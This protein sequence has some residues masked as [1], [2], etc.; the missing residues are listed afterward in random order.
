M[1]K[2]FG[3]DIKAP[4]FE[5]ADRGKYLVACGGV[6]LFE[7]F[8]NDVLTK[9]DFK[10]STVRL[11]CDGEVSTD[12]LNKTIDSLN[13]IF[14][15]N[16]RIFLFK[17]V[18][19]IFHSIAIEEEIIENIYKKGLMNNEIKKIGNS[20]PD[21]PSN[22]ISRIFFNAY[23]Q[24][25]IDPIRFSSALRSSGFCKYCSKYEKERTLLIINNWEKGDFTG[26]TVVDSVYCLVEI[27]DGSGSQDDTH[28]FRI[29]LKSWEDKNI[30]RSNIDMIR[31]DG[32]A[33]D[34]K[35]VLL[36]DRFNSEVQCNGPLYK[37]DFL[38]EL[39]NLLLVPVPESCYEDFNFPENYFNGNI[40]EK[41][42][43]I[44]KILNLCS[45]FRDRYNVRDYGN[46][47]SKE[48]DALDSV[49]LSFNYYVG[50]EHKEI[51]LLEL[52]NFIKENLDPLNHLHNFT[53][54]MLQKQV[55]KFGTVQDVFIFLIEKNLAL[56]IENLVGSILWE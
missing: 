2:Q 34:I 40:N 52:L 49:L 15:K 43:A 46:Y 17:L 8:C 47:Y 41:K 42:L 12:I 26:V 1:K 14:T 21:N 24:E 45:L 35:R 55:E 27:I 6:I 25:K 38:K 18:C 13:E 33:G 56:A 53:I 3:F 28:I 20:I 50:K 30:L 44:E 4:I 29:K 54:D 39:S 9:S 37:R 36:M 10:L 23:Y 7:D 48:I 22:L 31:D 16:H 51:E 32:M 11:F 19:M 5:I